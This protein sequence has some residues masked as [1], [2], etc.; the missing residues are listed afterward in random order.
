M[1]VGIQP[2]SGNVGAFGYVNALADARVCMHVLEPQQ[3]VM[4]VPP[5]GLPLGFNNIHYNNP[6]PVSFVF[7]ELV[8]PVLPP[9][10]PAFPFMLGCFPDI[11][12]LTGT[13][14]WTPIG[15]GFGSFPV[16]AI[17]PAFTGKLLFQ[18]VGF[19]SLQLSAPAVVDVQ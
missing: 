11:Y 19:P 3:H 12:A 5:L 2:V 13:P 1:Q 15:T 16:P 8:G 14:W 7:I 17:P 4:N 9:S 6:F 18:C 10:L